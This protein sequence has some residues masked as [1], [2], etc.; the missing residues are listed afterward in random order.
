M[1]PHSAQSVFRH[2]LTQILGSSAHVRTMRALFE[3]GGELSAPSIVGRTGL[4]KASVAGALRALERL[5]VIRRI[6]F[7]RA[8]LYRVQMRHPLAPPLAALFESEKTRFE[9][10]LDKLSEIARQSHA[11]AAWLY[12]SAARGED[13]LNSDVD[14]AVV[15]AADAETAERENIREWMTRVGDDFCFWASTTILDEKDV[16]RLSSQA[17]PWWVELAQDALTLSGDSPE[18]LAAQLTAAQRP[19]RRKRK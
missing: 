19:R 7:G 10:V 15:V 8:I 5:E 4:A 6:G 1:P 17:D 9:T 14:I 13:T 16:V 12:G 3:H 2:P 11:L 18:R